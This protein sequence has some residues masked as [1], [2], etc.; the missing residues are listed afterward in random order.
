MSLPLMEGRAQ[1]FWTCKASSAATFVA[2]SARA[3]AVSA[4]AKATSKPQELYQR[5]VMPL[6]LIGPAE[7][8]AHAP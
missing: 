8:D 1:A 2:Q 4:T 7:P 3:T 5:R 6:S